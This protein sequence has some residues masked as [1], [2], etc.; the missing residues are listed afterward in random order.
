MDEER[1]ALI[2][3]DYRMDYILPE[4]RFKDRERF[5][6]TSL[7]CWALDELEAYILSR[8]DMDPIDSTREFIRRMS[9]YMHRYKRTQ[10]RFFIAVDV[11][12]DIRDI[13]ICASTKEKENDDEKYSNIRK[14]N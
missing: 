11:A 7:V 14:T 8:A 12:E 2:I 5:E 3:A 13:L 1:I 9:Y 6:C 10:Q 4:M